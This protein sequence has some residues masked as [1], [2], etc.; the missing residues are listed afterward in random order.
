MASTRWIAFIPERLVQAAAG[1]AGNRA[2]D[3][4]PLVVIPGFVAVTISTT[5]PEVLRL[6]PTARSFPATFTEARRL[7]GD[8]L[9]S[10]SLLQSL[11]QF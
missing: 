9:P 1:I 3:A 5:V 7:L 2:E 8:D 11:V 4:V 6:V 10:V